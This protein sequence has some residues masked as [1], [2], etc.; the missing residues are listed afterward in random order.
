M[1]PKRERF[2]GFQ[3]GEELHS[4]LKKLGVVR[5]VKRIP[6]EIRRGLKTP[7]HFGLSKGWIG[8][9][10]LVGKD[11]REFFEEFPVGTIIEAVH[12]NNGSSFHYYV[13]SPEGWLQTFYKGE[14]VTV[15]NPFLLGSKFQKFKRLNS[16]IYVNVDGLIRQVRMR[17]ED[18]DEIHLFNERKDGSYEIVNNPEYRK[19]ER[20]SYQTTGDV[21]ILMSSAG[22]M[23]YLTWVRVVGKLATISPS[24][25]YPQGVELR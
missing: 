14:F 22:I 8:S 16:H 21:K 9:Y 12:M 7:E 2:L 24:F 1:G 15:E 19:L 18:S 17:F 25:N 5:D 6:D 20:V 13:K 23:N 4:Y 10:G 3:T 11:R